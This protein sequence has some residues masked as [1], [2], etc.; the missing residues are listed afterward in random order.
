MKFFYTY[1]REVYNEIAKSL[2]QDYIKEL[3][4]WLWVILLL[5]FLIIIFI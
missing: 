4:L 1:Y 5:G 2:K 3:P